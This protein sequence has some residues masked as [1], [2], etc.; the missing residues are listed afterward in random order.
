MAAGALHAGR[1]LGEGWVRERACGR[2]ADPTAANLREPTRIETFVLQR[3]QRGMVA[4]K[5]RRSRSPSGF[6]PCCSGAIPNS[7]KRSAMI[8]VAKGVRVVEQMLL[9][10]IDELTAG[11]GMD[12]PLR[13]VVPSQSLRQHL[14]AQILRRRGRGVAGVVV[15]TLFA[16]AVEV[17]DRCG[18]PATLDDILFPVIVEQIASG[19]PS[20]RNAFHDLTDGYASV[21][22]SVAD[23]LDAGFTDLHA[24]A[25]HDL[26][27]AGASGDAAAAR[28]QAVVRVAA[29]SLS[30]LERW[31]V[32]RPSLLLQRAR[33]A[34]LSAPERLLPARAL[35]VHGFADA[36]GVAA[37]LLEALLRQSNGTIYFDHPPDPADSSEVAASVAFTA[38]LRTHFSASETTPSHA[39][40]PGGSAAA[41]PDLPAN[42]IRQTIR[43]VRREGAA[44][45]VL[46]NVE[47][48][49]VETGRPRPASDGNADWRA[50]PPAPEETSLLLPALTLLRAPGTQAEV[51]AVA[52]RLRA[53]LDAGVR[54]ESIGIVA[55]DL[56]PYATALR[57]HCER[58]AI[59][60]SALAQRA[61]MD[62][63]GRRVVA[64]LDLL[65]LGGRAPIER[66]L[67]ATA[68]LG[69]QELR[70]VERADLRVALRAHGAA[71]IGEAAALDAGAT[72]AGRG[73]IP[74]PVRARLRATQ[75]A[76]GEAE[77]VADRR[78]LEGNLWRSAIAAAQN[79]LATWQQWPQ[80]AS[81]EEHGQWAVR[82]LGDELGWPEHVEPRI[83]LRRLQQTLPPTFELQREEFLGLLQRQSAEIGRAPIGG[84]GGGVQVLSVVEARARTWEH[85][86]VLG[87]NRDVFPRIIREDPLL[88]DRLRRQALSLLPDLPIKEVGYD[89]ERYLFAQ[90]LSSSPNIT[91]SWQI[92]DDEG[93][94]C[95]L[96]TLVE[97]LLSGRPDLYVEST[98][99]VFAEE[100][101]STPVTQNGVGP[102][103]LAMP[104]LAP[105][106]VGRAAR[107]LRPATEHATLA[108]LYGSRQAFARVLPMAIAEIAPEGIDV[109]AFSRSRL[110]VLEE[111]DPVATSLPPH[112]IGPYFG[113]VGAVRSPADLRRS[114]M[115]VTTLE[116]VVRCPWQTFLLRLLGLER[117]PD[118]LASLPTITALMLG[119]T[120]HKFLEDLV[121]DAAG[122]RPRDLT[123]LV[124]LPA[125][126]VPWPDASSLS[127]RLRKAAEEVL[128]KE[129]IGIP[130]F[131]HVLVERAR[132]YVHTAQ[133]VE[134]GLSLPAVLGAEAEG[135]IT[136]PSEQRVW[137][138]A[139]RV[140]RVGSGVRLTDYKTGRPAITLKTP[141]KQRQTLLRKIAAGE[142]L[143]ATAY[144]M[145]AQNVSA[146]AGG[147]RYSYVKPET[148]EHALEI[149]IA[150]GDMEAA[151]AFTATVETARQAWDRGSFFPRLSE[152]G[153]DSEPSRCTYCEVS[154]A[155][156]RGDTGARR[157]LRAWADE[158]EP[159]P[160]SGSEQAAHALWQL[161]AKDAKDTEKG[162]Q[163]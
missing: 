154:S 1:S 127:M 162:E 126:S 71:R 79:L 17:L 13:I 49:F 74:L 113:L 63:I 142:L 159:P 55:R 102:N 106:A 137:F 85:L 136:L 25:L 61:P 5:L 11:N 132:P 51:R 2:E 52:N 135:S 77:A 122:E 88:P 35:L 81:A 53:L 66:W 121:T 96:S 84:A 60:F 73:R 140:D 62:G 58:L 27:A 93:K 99:A 67:D 112:G 26:F 155:C 108:A 33:E 44:S 109:A 90:L 9:E 156:L 118:P 64:V 6:F 117:L 4:I 101:K 163:E 110:A 83:T 158:A 47:D 133:A 138:R 95:S 103:Q 34:Y 82:V 48:L 20:L 56:A 98:P 30:A 97:R 150:A 40:D 92:L 105:V 59:P 144:A 18:E 36:T 38:R 123:S 145:A 80:R 54:P 141:E 116:R 10:R 7:L 107:D 50:T 157:R 125:V 19:E 15:Q 91:L 16:A 111:L 134:W 12:P 70:I 41:A 120:V 76:D 128:R 72:L 3:T 78:S 152:P 21:T 160:R 148:E 31:A 124:D 37:D 86:F 22:A 151:A 149:L 146:D 161:V 119:S 65:R 139:D 68:S 57:L 131:A 104:F 130:G 39:E 24:E 115:F 153:K 147:G 100:A 28:A 45:P 143:Q 114:P 14:S 29:H 43:L 42:S 69:N 23:L 89:E 75:G 32:R 94:A 87:M 8:V 129:G 46:T